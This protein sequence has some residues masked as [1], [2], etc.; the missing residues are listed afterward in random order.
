MGLCNF[1]I[2]PPIIAKRFLALPGFPLFYKGLRQLPPCGIKILT[3]IDGLE[4]GRVIFYFRKLPGKKNRSGY[5]RLKTSGKR[6]FITRLK[7]MY[8]MCRGAGGRR[9]WIFRQHE[10]DYPAFS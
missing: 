4:S 6:F 9:S 10:T 7:S 3:R 8:C 1:V 2:T 5:A